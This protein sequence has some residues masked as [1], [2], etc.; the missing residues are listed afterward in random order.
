MADFSVDSFSKIPN[1]Q[2]LMLLGGLIAAVIG[3]YIYFIHMPSQEKLMLTR[4]QLTKVQAKY[5]EQQKVLADLP[6]FERELKKLELKFANSLKLLPNTREIPSLL[7]N[8]STLAQDSGL[9]ILLFEPKP[10]QV[11]DFYAEIPVNMTVLGDYHNVGYFFDK[12]SKLN[13]IVN[14][15]AIKIDSKRAKRKGTTGPN[16]ESSFKAV[17]FKFI[18]KEKAGGKKKDRKKGRKRR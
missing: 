8:I 10:E 12:V 11:R 15:S 13:R 17:T 1:N 2:K 3:S 9:E 4:E 18:E 5:N 14:I 6:K 16:L 7:T